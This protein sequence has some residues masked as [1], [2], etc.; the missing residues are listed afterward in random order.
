METTKRKTFLR[1]SSRCVRSGNPPSCMASSFFGALSSCFRFIGWRPHRLKRPIDVS[2]GPKY[3]PYVDFQ[4]IPDHWE[5]MFGTQRE[6]TERHFRNSLISAIGST[7]LSVIIGAMA[8]YGL[9]RF[10]YY[11][12]RLGWDN[13][14]IAFWIISQRFLPPAIFIVPFVLLY[15]FFGLIDT[16]PGLIIAYT[17]F[18]IPFAVWIM[19][20]FFNG[21]ANRPGGERAG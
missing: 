18:N 15:N 2:R 14:N 9:S 6:S 8:G 5:E 10:R 12:A 21:L 3:I 13:D 16:Y 7:I 20:D 1:R 19:R 17:M 11:W 4:P